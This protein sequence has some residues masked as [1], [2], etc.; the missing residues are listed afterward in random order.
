MDHPLQQEDDESSAEIQ[1]VQ[2]LAGSECPP[3]VTLV[4]SPHVNHCKCAPGFPLTC[5]FFFFFHLLY[6]TKHFV[7]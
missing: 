7:L 4:T 1:E 3:A 6:W 2:E 5:F